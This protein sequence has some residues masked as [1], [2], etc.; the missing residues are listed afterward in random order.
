MLNYQQYSPKECLL[1][2][3]VVSKIFFIN[4]YKATAK[5]HCERK[6]EFIRYLIPKVVSL[7]FLIIEKV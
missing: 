6:H 5:P 3:V 7:D 2:L 1:P 4:H